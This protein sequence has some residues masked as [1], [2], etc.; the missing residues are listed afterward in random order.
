M[1]RRSRIAWLY[2]TRP[3]MRMRRDG[4]PPMLARMSAD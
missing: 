3:N 4:H 1:I 2:A